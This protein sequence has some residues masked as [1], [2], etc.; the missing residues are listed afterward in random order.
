MIQP[1]NIPAPVPADIEPSPACITVYNIE[2]HCGGSEEG[3][4]YYTWYTPLFSVPLVAGVDIDEQVERAKE[5]ARDA[6]GAVF[7]GDTVNTGHGDRQARSHRSASPEVDAVAMLEAV[8]LEN[9]STE[10][11]HYE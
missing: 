8:A 9:Q 1:T 4:W 10:R 2:L 11:P 6:H 5:S 3:G 7:A